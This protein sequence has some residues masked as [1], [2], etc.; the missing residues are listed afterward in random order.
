MTVL[1]I[2]GIM[3]GIAVPSF[4]NLIKSMRIE[5]DTNEFIALMSY[6]RAYALDSGEKITV[7]AVNGADNTNEWGG[8]VTVTTSGGTTIRDLAAFVTPVFDSQNDIG[9][10]VFNAD[11]TVDTADTITVCDDRSGETGRTLTL[12]GGG[13]IVAEQLVCP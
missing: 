10:Y 6:A 9:T 4:T 1:A 13:V 5:A 7:T 3:L 2:A 11:G 12:V 8:G